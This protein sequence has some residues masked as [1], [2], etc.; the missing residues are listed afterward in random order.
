MQLVGVVHARSCV[1]HTHT[2]ARQSCMQVSFLLNGRYPTLA[3]RMTGQL[4]CHADPNQ[5]RQVNFEYL[6]QQ[7]IWG[8]LQ[9]FVIFLLPLLTP[10]STASNPMLTGIVDPLVKIMAGGDLVPCLAVLCIKSNSYDHCAVSHYFP[11]CRLKGSGEAA[12]S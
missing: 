8:E 2:V 10:G 12:L 11:A 5:A 6:N 4:L 7:L 1:F 9:Q 3:H